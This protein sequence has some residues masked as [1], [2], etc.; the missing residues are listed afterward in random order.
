MIH[1]NVINPVAE[2]LAAF[3]RDPALNLR[4]RISAILAE[5][6]EQI[7]QNRNQSEMAGHLADWFFAF[8][9]AILRNEDIASVVQ[10]QLPLLQNLLS[11]PQFQTNPMVQNVIQTLLPRL[12]TIFPKIVPILPTH[13]A[14]T[15]NTNNRKGL[16]RFLQGCALVQLKWKALDKSLQSLQRN[17]AQ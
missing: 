9:D 1:N 6:Y 8:R 2:P 16:E 12:Q 3:L 13:Q 17:L 4:R 7:N 5:V 15:P 14:S 11:N 10:Q